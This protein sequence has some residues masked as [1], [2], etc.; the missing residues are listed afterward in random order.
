MITAKQAQ[1]LMK[2]KGTVRG[3][4][5][6]IDYDNINTL[7]GKDQVKKVENYIKNLGVEINYES[8]K[9]TALYP[10]GLRFISLIAIKDLFKLTDNDIRKMGFNAPRVSFIVKLFTRAF[11]SVDALLN[12]ANIIWQK[13]FNGS[14]R[15]IKYSKQKKYITAQL[16]DFIS[17][18][19]FCKYLKGYFESIVQLTLPNNKV[20][21]KEV[22]CDN[23]KGIHRF[24][25]TWK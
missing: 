21:A 7:F 12:R 14:L 3:V 2:L 11:L 9:N 20:T 1:E 16:E 25:L 13:H 8:F 17:H 10:V 5:F 23:K 24:K 18:P 6:R 4:A 15:V 19:V 22:L